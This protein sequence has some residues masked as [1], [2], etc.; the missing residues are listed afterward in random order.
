MADLA[1]LELTVVISE[2]ARTILLGA[3]IM[4]V[5]SDSDIAVRLIPHGLNPGNYGFAGAVRVFYFE[6]VQ[7]LASGISNILL[8]I[9]HDHSLGKSA[10]W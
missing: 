3:E 8:R 4:S 2:G 1:R 5:S 9:L 6:L 7:E 10:N